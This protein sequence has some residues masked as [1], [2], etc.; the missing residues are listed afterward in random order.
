MNLPLNHPLP[1]LEADV[2][3]TFVAIVETGSFSAAAQSVLRTPSAVSMQIK[4]LEEMLGRPVFER[5]SRSVSLTPDGEVLLSY[6]HRLLA[7]NREAVSRFVVPE[8]VGVVKLG[9]PD[10]VSERMLPDILRRF[11]KAHP[12]VIVD[13]V[14]DETDSMYKRLEAGRLDVAIVNCS[15]DT[16]PA[17]GELL[18]KEPLVWAGRR[19]GTAH[20]CCPLP[21]SVWEEGCAWRNRAIE[22]LEEAG[23]EY[24]IAYMSAYTSGQRSAV[25]SDLAIAPLGLSSI[26][27]DIMVLGEEYGLPDLGTYNISMVVGP[28][29]GDPALAAAD[30]IRCA[31]EAIDGKSRPGV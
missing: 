13:V 23:I 22:A 1:L 5:D 14:V 29:A 26:T 31:F 7:I 9:A 6:A 18:L 12:D 11:A 27:E 8:V 16:I 28:K 4:K 19:G 15:T 24:R 3:R 2:L 10:E 20:N 17:G 30:H 21:I 25:L